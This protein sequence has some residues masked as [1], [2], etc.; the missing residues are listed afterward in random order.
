MTVQ[1]LT[2]FVGFTWSHAGGCDHLSR[3]SFRWGAGS[4]TQRSR[5]TVELGASG[6][7]EEAG[8]WDDTQAA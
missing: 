8:S 4:C 1:W 3:Q 6:L 5:I 2:P 7:L